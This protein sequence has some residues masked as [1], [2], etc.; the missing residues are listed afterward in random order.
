M[1]SGASRQLQIHLHLDSRSNERGMYHKIE[2]VYERGIL[3]PLQQL[4]LAESHKSKADYH[5]CAPRAQPT[6]HP[7]SRGAEVSAIGSIP[8]IEE[9]LAGLASIPGSLAQVLIDERAD[10]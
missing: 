10:Y 1:E 5:G 3:R 6:R 7:T 9:V 2:A 4:L 8:S